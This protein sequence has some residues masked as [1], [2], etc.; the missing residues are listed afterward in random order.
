LKL[1]QYTGPFSAGQTITIPAQI[2]YSYV[3]IGIQ[4]PK[5]QPIA[6]ITE[7]ALPID[8]TFNG[9]GYR[10]NDAGILEFDETTET[11]IDIKIERDLP[12]ESTI[13]IAYNV[14]SQ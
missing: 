7:T 3:H 1:I 2:D 6:L 14:A 13:D 11:T 8:I 10:V 4:I 12:W 9:V 5:R